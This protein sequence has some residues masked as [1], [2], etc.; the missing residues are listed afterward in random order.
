MIPLYDISLKFDDEIRILNFDI[1]VIIFV[2][3][4]F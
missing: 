3:H 2:F 4:Y 1:F